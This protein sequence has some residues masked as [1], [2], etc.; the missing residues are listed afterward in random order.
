MAKRRCWPWPKSVTQMARPARL[1]STMP[2]AT[3]KCRSQ[4][5]RPETN[6]NRRVLM[7]K[8][9]MFT[10]LVFSAGIAGAADSTQDPYCQ[11]IK[12]K[13]TT[14]Q[15]NIDRANRDKIKDQSAYLTIGDSLGP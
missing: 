10:V 7:R 13:G 4:F 6:A 12:S 15:E 1:R 9:L 14:S 8:G 5:W 2:A 11:E 3:R